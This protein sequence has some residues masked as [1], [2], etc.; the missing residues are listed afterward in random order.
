MLEVMEEK[1]E[2]AEKEAE[3]EAGLDLLTPPHCVILELDALLTPKCG[4]ARQTGQQLNVH[5]YFLFP[6]GRYRRSRSPSSYRKCRS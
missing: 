2:K 6:S 5:A 3:K 4:F 1:A